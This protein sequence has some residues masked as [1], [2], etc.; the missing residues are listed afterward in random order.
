MPSEDICGAAVV[1]KDPTYVVSRK[2]YR[3]S[4]NVC[5]DNKGIVVWVVLKP[6]VTF[7]KGDWDVRL[8]SAEMHAF[9]DIGDGAEVFFPL[10]LHLVD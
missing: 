9:V 4:A 8:G 2:V 1:N 5:M 10:T 6:E 7:E 3:V